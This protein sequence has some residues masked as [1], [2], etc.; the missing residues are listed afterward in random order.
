MFNL[1]EKAPFYKN[2]SEI[3]FEDIQ[4]LIDNQ[5]SEGWY[6]E[7]KES[8]PSKN[9]KVARSIASFANSDGGWYVIGI[10]EKSGKSYADEI[11]PLN[12][13]EIEG[14]KEK[15]AL[16]VKDRIHPTPIFE[17]KIVG[18]GEDEFVLVV[19]VDKGKDAP[20]LT[21]GSIY[22]RVG[23]IS[24]PKPLS[25]RYLLEKLIDRKKEFKLKIDEFCKNE[26]VN[27]PNFNQPLLEFY[28]YLDDDNLFFED[29]FTSEFMDELK[30]NFNNGVEIL[31]EVNVTS[32][33][34]FSNMYS[35]LNSYILQNT[36]MNSIDNIGCAI[37]FF[38]NG[39]F[40]FI[41]PL[42]M[43]DKDEISPKLYQFYDSDLKICNL[44]SSMIAFDTVMSQYKR[45]LGKQAFNGNVYV[46]FNLKNCFQLALYFDDDLFKDYIL[47]NGVP[48]SFK[49][50]VNVKYDE[51][52][53][54]FDLESFNSKSFIGDIIKSVGVSDKSVDSYSANFA[55]VITSNIKPYDD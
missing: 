42:N 35:T 11:T 29:F 51:K 41:L 21:D 9:Y 45:L 48:I 34:S 37:E 30:N 27:L 38:I 36:E 40:K 10:K 3:E 53:M 39:N 22:Q 43:M 52:K 18:C 1:K 50:E 33:I 8:F 4:M 26:F 47:E 24:D 32:S 44:P 14:L 5:V 54:I 46:R 12:L 15:I 25:D 55:K 2:I 16:I 6:I 19:Y 20:Y 7:Y 13:E 31:P 49:S 28:V 23:E 17:S